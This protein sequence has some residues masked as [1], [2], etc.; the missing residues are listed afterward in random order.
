MIPIIY[1]ALPPMASAPA[2][3]G[4]VLHPRTGLLQV[5][6]VG[7]TAD[8]CRGRVEAWIEAQR[9]RHRNKVRAAGAVPDVDLG[10]LLS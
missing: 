5:R 8:Q 7:D 10:D 9:D 1:A 4:F 3:V 2:F 6:F